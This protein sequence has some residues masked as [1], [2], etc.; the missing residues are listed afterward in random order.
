MVHITFSFPQNRNI[1]T[2]SLYSSNGNTN[3]SYEL[4]MS[5]WEILIS[6]ENHRTVADV[7]HLIADMQF[8]SSN[9]CKITNFKTDYLHLIANMQQVLL[10][11]CLPYP[12][13]HH[14]ISNRLGQKHC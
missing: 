12:R 4:I 11:E 13:P 2:N 14:S 8:L 9:N 7:I 6:P 1:A 5:T 3:T 10:S